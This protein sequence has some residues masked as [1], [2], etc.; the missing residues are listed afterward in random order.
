[1]VADPALVADAETLGLDLVPLAETG[2]P[3]RVNRDLVRAL[4]EAGLFSRIFD[5]D[6]V[7]A[8]ELCQLRQGLA[9]S[10]PEAE[11]AFAVQG[12]GGTPILTAGSPAVHARWKESLASGAAVA[13]FALTESGAG[14]D[15][16]ALT[17]SAERDGEGFRITGEKVYISNAPDADVAAVFARTTAGAGAKGVTAFAVPIESE[18]VTGEEI[19]MLSPHPLGRW[20]F[21]GVFVPEENVLGDIDG[22][23]VVAMKTLDLFRPSVGAFALGMAESALRIAVEHAATRQA[24]G[25]PISEFQGVTHPLADVRTGIEAATQLVYGAASA[26]DQGDKT[27]LTGKAAMA[28]LFATELAQDAVDVAIQVLGAR[29]L[30]ADSTLAHLYREVRAPRIYEG[31]SEIQRNIIA[32]ELFRGRI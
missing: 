24:F 23:F 19:E 16:A 7:T 11:T 3:G 1:M 8:T 4:G 26:Y 22:G 27:G 6:D 5:A 21:D 17:M 15:A 2:T 32:R 14:S 31:T 20:V 12:L 30:E 29:G 9:R 10:C 13:A 18:G 25:T 28:K